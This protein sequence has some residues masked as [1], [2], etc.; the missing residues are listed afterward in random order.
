LGVREAA[1]N[2]SV[3]WDITVT[4]GQAAEAQLLPCVLD[5]VGLSIVEFGRKKHELEE[6]FIN[7]V[8]GGNNGC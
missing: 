7:I 8:E 3:T 4:D 2:G 1:R 6:I 5:G